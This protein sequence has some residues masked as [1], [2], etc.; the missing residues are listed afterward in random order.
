M[1]T[2]F[3]GG[4]IIVVQLVS[5]HV[6]ALIFDWQFALAFQVLLHCQERL[7]CID[8][9]CVRLASGFVRDTNGHFLHG[10]LNVISCLKLHFLDGFSHGQLFSVFGQNL[11]FRFE[12][13]LGLRNLRFEICQ[14]IVI[15]FD[16]LQLQRFATGKVHKKCTC[17]G[18]SPFLLGFHSRFTSL[19][20]FVFSSIEHSSRSPRQE[21]HVVFSNIQIS[22]GFS[23]LCFHFFIS[24]QRP[25][26]VP[27]IRSFT[28]DA[29]VKILVII[30]IFGN[31]HTADMARRHDACIIEIVWSC[32]PNDRT[33]IV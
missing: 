32:F 5:I 2:I 25:S 24:R 19:Q 12:Q 30:N 14:S 26:R 7:R 8:K 29:F 15:N 33:F 16:I 27:L 11:S 22:F 10:Q 28:A 3:S 4:L 13:R 9:D 21:I 17:L 31:V 18:R 20:S 1:N 6:Q 23:D